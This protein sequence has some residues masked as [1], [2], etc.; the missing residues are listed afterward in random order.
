MWEAAIRVG[1]L[2]SGNSELCM[3]MPRIKRYFLEK[4]K[5]FLLWRMSNRH[6]GG[7]IDYLRE[8]KFIFW[9]GANSFSEGGQIHFLRGGKYFLGGGK[10]ISARFARQLFLPPPEF[11][12]ST[13]LSTLLKFDEQLIGNNFFPNGYPNT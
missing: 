7:Q 3:C 9:G 12:L 6:G 13:A 8:S 5:C 4:G 1:C 11:S 2:V 10:K